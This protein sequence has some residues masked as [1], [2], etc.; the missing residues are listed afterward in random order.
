MDEHE[1][2]RISKNAHEELYPPPHKGR[3]LW[4][5]NQI[6]NTTPFLRFG[7]TLLGTLAFVGAGILVWTMWERRSVGVG[8]VL[9][10]LG[11]LAIGILSAH[12]GYIYYLEKL[13][14]RH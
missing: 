3:G 10:V 9:F 7:S 14:R 8:G 6:K 12:E 2:H 5:Y 4:S 11:A 13:F 1:F